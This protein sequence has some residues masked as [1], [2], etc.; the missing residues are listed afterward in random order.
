MIATL[1]YIITQKYFSR[2]HYHIIG[3]D[4]NENLILNSTFSRFNVRGFVSIIAL[5]SILL[6]CL[7]AH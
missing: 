6:L 2:M 1:T 3:V 7:N 5:N 4:L